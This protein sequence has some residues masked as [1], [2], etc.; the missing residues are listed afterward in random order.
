V[1]LT[2]D[3]KGRLVTKRNKYNVS[4]K[5]DR[6]VDGI[7]FA[8]KRE[9]TRYSELRLMQKCGSIHE[10][11]LQPKFA[12]PM[13]FSYVADFRYCERELTGE[14]IRHKYVTEDVKGIQTPVFRLKRK[15]MAYFYPEVDLRLV[16]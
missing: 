12:F 4:P 3:R 11:K 8:S 13:G 2:L 14:G 9:A 16:K 7:V 1:T 10:L 6:T 15:C 5:E